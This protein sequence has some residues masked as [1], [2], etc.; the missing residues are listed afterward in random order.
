M[1]DIVSNNIER[2]DIHVLTRKKGDKCDTT[3]FR[4][5]RTMMTESHSSVLRLLFVSPSVFKE[6]CAEFH[7]SNNY[8]RLIVR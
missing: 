3:N 7:P 4:R 8:P 5:L 6:F 2:E 1:L